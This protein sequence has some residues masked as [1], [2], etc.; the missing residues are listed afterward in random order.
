MEWFLGIIAATVVFFSAL[1]VGAEPIVFELPR[2]MIV[3]EK[4]EVLFGGDLFF[5]RAIRIAMEVH[6]HDYPHSCIHPALQSEQ[7]VDAILES[8]IASADSR[9]AGKTLDERGH[10]TFTF[11]TST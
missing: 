5:D 10:C 1:F 9:S 11:P 2:P 4:A 3:E 7:I 8:P 6:G